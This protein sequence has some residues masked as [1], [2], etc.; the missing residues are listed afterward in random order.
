MTWPRTAARVL[1]PGD[2]FPAAV[3]QARP[4]AYAAG[5]TSLIR[6]SGSVVNHYGPVVRPDAA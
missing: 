6:F 3:H 4:D 2:Y 5:T 1:G